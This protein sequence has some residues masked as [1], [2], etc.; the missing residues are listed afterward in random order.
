[1][2]FFQNFKTFIYLKTGIYRDMAKHK[3]LNRSEKKRIQ[4]FE[5]DVK[6][7]KKLWDSIEKIHKEDEGMFSFLK[8]LFKKKPAKKAA[9]KKKK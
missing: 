7:E 9:K 8:K 1:L 4:T 6:E 2:K 3:R 5:K